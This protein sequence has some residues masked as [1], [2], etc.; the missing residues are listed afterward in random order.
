MTKR[1]DRGII[2]TALHNKIGEVP[3][4]LNVSTAIALESIAEK[5]KMDD[6]DYYQVF[7]ALTLQKLRSEFAKT[8]YLAK[9][10]ATQK[11]KLEQNE[12]AGTTAFLLTLL[13]DRLLKTNAYKSSI[14]DEFDYKH[15][16]DIFIEDIVKEYDIVEQDIK[17]GMAGALDTDDIEFD[18]IRDLLDLAKEIKKAKK[19]IQ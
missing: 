17:I 12:S 19:N 15:I 10:N 2:A 1:T 18:E 6:I 16:V 4:E 14:L 13:T 11:D 3:V 7:G 8:L 9:S 5:G